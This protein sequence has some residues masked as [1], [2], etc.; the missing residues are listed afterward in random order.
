M[1][2]TLAWMIVAIVFIVA[3]ASVIIVRMILEFR[4]RR[5]R[6]LGAEELTRIEAAIDALRKDLR[7][8]VESPFLSER[9]TGFSP[10]SP[11]KGPDS[12]SSEE[13]GL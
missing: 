1:P 7:Q 8:R 10:D 13:I 3:A 11:R 4:L 6:A 9:P 12:M 5:S 2:V